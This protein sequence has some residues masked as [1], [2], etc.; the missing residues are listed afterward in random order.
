MAWKDFEEGHCDECHCYGKVRVVIC[1]LGQLHYFCTGCFI[2]KV[3]DIKDGIR[4]R[5]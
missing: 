5:S 3:G 1:E 2:K 4:E